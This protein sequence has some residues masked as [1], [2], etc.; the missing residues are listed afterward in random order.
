M[1][2]THT[3]KVTFAAQEPSLPGSGNWEEDFAFSRMSKV[4]SR[5]VTRPVILALALMASTAAIAVDPVPVGYEV[6]T[7]PVLSA[8]F[9]RAPSAR[10]I[11]LKEARRIALEIMEEAEQERLRTAEEEA[12]VG[13]DWS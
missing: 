11:S 13:I 8:P 4:P 3:S 2:E 9:N 5:G 6:P 1:T 10:R 12:A 7:S